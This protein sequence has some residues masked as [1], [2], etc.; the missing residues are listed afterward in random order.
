MSDFIKQCLEIYPQEIFNPLLEKL[1]QTLPSPPWYV[2]GYGSCLSQFTKTETSAPDFYVIVKDYNSFYPRKR[3]TML[4]QVIPPNI[5]HFEDQ[6]QI[7]KY[8][9]ISAFD[10]EREVSQDA[11][12]VYHLGRFS[13]R[14]AM[15][16]KQNE[17]ALDHLTRI[18]QS[19]IETALDFS[20]KLHG[21]A[22]HLVDAIKGALQL[23]YDGDVRIESADKVQKI[24]EAE[25]EYYLEVYRPCFEQTKTVEK[26]TTMSF[27]I[28]KSR[29][30][31]QMRWIKNIFTA[32]M[33][34]DYMIFKIE[35][36]QGIKIELTEQQKKLWPIY[37]WPIL[38]KLLREKR[39]R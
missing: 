27:W 39:I 18:H 24:W 6:N 15:I 36:T 21:P 28:R 32:S 4:N 33:W 35:R 8:S 16:W 14:I 12:D 23:S 7:L 13:K 9:V 19:A 11:H 34:V 31:A 37:I 25:Q 10:L 29:L 30:R 20:Q 17:E 3:S 5:Y 1:L 38:F 2:V 26:S 22:D